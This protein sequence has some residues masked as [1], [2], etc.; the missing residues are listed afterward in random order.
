LKKQLKDAEPERE[1]KKYP[2]QP[3]EIPGS[4]RLEKTLANE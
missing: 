3:K 2:F 1:I 4:K